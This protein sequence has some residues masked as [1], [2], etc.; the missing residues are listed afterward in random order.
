MRTPT[1]VTAIVYAI[2][3]SQVSDDELRPEHIRYEIPLRVVD[4]GA[5]EVYVE[6]MD[7]HTDGEWREIATARLFRRTEGASFSGWVV[8]TSR[9]NSDVIRGKKHALRNLWAEVEERL[10]AHIVYGRTQARLV[11]VYT[12]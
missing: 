11:D 12:D 7:N 2:P 1:D 9:S 6:A 4:T 3:L 8:E 5:G 10:N